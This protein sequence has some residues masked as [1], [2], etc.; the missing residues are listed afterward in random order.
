MSISGVS[1]L[2][3]NEAV[4]RGFYRNAPITKPGAA[5]TFSEADMIGLC[6]FGHLLRLNFSATEAA[7]IASNTASVVND[8]RIHFDKLHLIYGPNGRV[9]HHYRAR[10]QAPLV[11]D[12]AA[13]VTIDFD[14]IRRQIT[15]GYETELLGQARKLRERA[16]ALEASLLSRKDQR[17]LRQIRALLEEADLPEEVSAEPADA[18]KEHAE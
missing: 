18:E 17:E 12:A 4:A 7:S 11:I 8:Q 1:P 9:D 6:T 10:G 13:Y 15:E 5:R 16:A 14:V 3:F 2:R